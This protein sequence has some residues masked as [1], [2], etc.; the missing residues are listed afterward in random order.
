MTYNEFGDLV[1]LTT[2]RTNNVTWNGTSW[3]NPTGGDVPTWYYD[4]PTG[5]LTNKTD[6]AGNS[7]TYDYYVN[8]LPKATVLARGVGTLT[9]YAGNGDLV[10]L[11][12]KNDWTGSLVVSSVISSNYNRMA[13]PRSVIKI[14]RRKTE[15]RR[16]P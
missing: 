7:V 5:L 16:I 6:A 2:Y 12:L 10:Q 14:C 11:D 8:Y 15:G 13:L 9:S 3:P 4:A 1:T